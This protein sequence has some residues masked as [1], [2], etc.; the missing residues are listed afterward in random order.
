MQF[1]VDAQLPP[2]LARWLTAAGHPSEHVADIGMAAAQD[3][4][5]WEYAERN[6][7]VIVTKDQDFAVLR[8][9]SDAPAPSVVWLRVGNS[10]RPALLRWFEPLLPAILSALAEGT[11]LVEIE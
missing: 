3:S 9:V 7:A 1:L 8:I 6:G 5:V 4:A 10:R 11:R 2:A